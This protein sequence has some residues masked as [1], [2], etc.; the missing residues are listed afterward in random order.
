MNLTDLTI[1]E[2]ITTLILFIPTVVE[3]SPIKINPWSAIFKKIGQAV[4][5][6]VLKELAEVKKEQQETRKH[7]DEH[8]HFA[9]ERNADE[10]RARILRF[11]RELLRN[12]PHTHEDFVD[13]LKDID[14]YENYCGTHKDYENGRAVHAI[15][16]INRVYDESMQNGNFCDI[17]KEEEL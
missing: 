14:Y 1:G 16:N 12:I 5:A 8:V 9:D 7:L 3:V 15:A 2:L 6:D 4:N 11:N 10:H 17:C 13:V